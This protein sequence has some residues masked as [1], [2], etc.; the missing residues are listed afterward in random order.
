MDNLPNVIPTALIHIINTLERDSGHQFQWKLTRNLEN[1][2][3]FVKCEIRA[4]SVDGEKPFPVNRKPGSRKYKSPSALRRQRARKQ[5]FQ[6]KKA[7]E[8][9]VLP[10]SPASGVNTTVLQEQ[11]SS[12]VSSKDSCIDLDVTD[13]AQDLAC[14]KDKCFVNQTSESEN[15]HSP[16]SDLATERALLLDILHHTDIDS[17][18]NSFEFPDI[19][20]CSNC[21]RQPQK[22]VEALLTVSNNQVL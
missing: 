13:H 9:A 15:I 2:S 4:K 1:I 7:A 17:D 6:K 12:S 14:S 11:E 16:D 3:L 21:K 19:N 8:K 20:I 18:D 10:K 5:R 22:G